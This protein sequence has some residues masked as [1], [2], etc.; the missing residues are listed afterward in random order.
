MRV[1]PPAKQLRNLLPRQPP[2]PNID[3]SSNSRVCV[4]LKSLSVSVCLISLCS[5]CLLQW[6]PPC[7][8]WCK[9]PLIRTAPVTRDFYFSVTRCFPCRLCL[10]QCSS[11]CRRTLSAV[12]HPQFS[13]VCVCVCVCVCV[14]TVQAHTSICC[15][16]VYVVVDMFKSSFRATWLTPAKPA[17]LQ[18]FNTQ[19]HT[20]T[21]EY[22]HTH[23]HAHNSPYVYCSASEYEFHNSSLQR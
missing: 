12:C 7:L 5:L 22:R 16:C 10:K 2:R 14:E 23:N 1:K 17:T 15:G 8:L 21:H 11:P 9:Q 18:S 20:H 4:G 19:S 13:G 3:P 6:L